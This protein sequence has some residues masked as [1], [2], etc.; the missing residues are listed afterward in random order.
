MIDNWL[1]DIQQCQSAMI[2]YY[3]P[4]PSQPNDIAQSRILSQSP[5]NVPCSESVS[6]SLWRWPQSSSTPRTMVSDDHRASIILDAGKK[7]RLLLL[8]Q[9]ANYF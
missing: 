8:L 6:C 4:V 5:N 1:V 3:R 2:T 9:R 7:G